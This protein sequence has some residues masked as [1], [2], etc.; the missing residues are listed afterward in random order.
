MRVSAPRR[1]EIRIRMRD[2]TM[3]AALNRQLYEATVFDSG[4]LGLST[5]V[6]HHVTT[7]AIYWASVSRDGKHTGD[8]AIVVSDDAAAVQLAIDLAKVQPGDPHGASRQTVS[9]KGYVVFHATSGTG[10]SVQLRLGRRV[11]FD[12]TH[13]KKGDIFALTLIEP[14]HYKIENKLGS[15]KGSAEVRFTRA[16]VKRLSELKPIT[17][18]VSKSFDPQHF[19][20]ISTQGLIYRI[21]TD[22]RIVITRR[23][24]R[25]AK[26][27]LPEAD[28]EM[29]LAAIR[30][31]R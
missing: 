20:L 25:V 17:V 10:W 13:L 11:I 7:A 27:H 8:V 29:A 14:A 3:A 2:E 22:A 16:D 30:R 6:V 1:S 23:E 21:E 31:F 28:P 15:A 26:S 9:T 24:K 18:E 4:A 5:S 19:K 12:S